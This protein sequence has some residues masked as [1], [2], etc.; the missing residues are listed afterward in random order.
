MDFTMLTLAAAILTILQNS[1]LDLTSGQTVATPIPIHNA[2]NPVLKE[3]ISADSQSLMVNG[4]RV[5]WAMGEFHYSRYPESEWRHELQKMK[6]GGINVISTYIIWIHHEES[7]DQWKWEGNKDLRKFLTLCKELGLKAFVRGGPWV[8]A[9]VRNGGFPDWMASGFK[10]RSDDPSYLAKV[11]E[12]YGQISKQMSGLA[13][14]DGGPIVGFQV[15]NEYYGP[16]E[17]LLNLKRMAQEVGINVPLYTRTGWP[18]LKTPVPPNEL[19]PMYGGYPIGFWDRGIEETAQKYGRNYTLRLDRNPDDILQGDAPK[20]KTLEVESQ[21]PYMCCEI[22]GG[23]HVSYHRR[24]VV[25]P[26]DIGSLAMAKVASGNNLQG[27][28]MYHGGTNPEGNTYLSESQAT[29]YWNDVPVK[30][31]DFQAP[32]GEFGQLRPHYHYLRRLHLFMKDFGHELA[33]M[34]AQIGS[35]DIANWSVRSNGESGFIFVNNYVRQI[36]QSVRKGVQFSL[37]CK[38]GPLTVP[39]KPIDIPENSYF[40]WPFHQD[41]S[42]VQLTYATAQPVCKLKDSYFFGQIKGVPAEFA[43]PVGDAKVLKTNAQSTISGGQVRLTKLKT[44]LE[45]AI[46]LQ[47]KDGKLVQI[48]LLAEAQSFHTWKGSFG[49]KEVVVVADDDVLFDRNQLQLTSRPST[50]KFVAIMPAFGPITIGGAAVSPS[51]VGEFSVYHYANPVPASIPITMNQTAVMTAP[52]EVVEGSQGVAEQPVDNDFD[53]ASKWDIILPKELPP[54]NWVLK[55]KYQGDV[56]RIY[57]N[58]NFV[59]DNF[60][61]GKPFE[62]GLNRGG[63]SLLRGSLSLSVLPWRKDALIYFTPGMKPDVEGKTGA[64]NVI[65][66]ELV[67]TVTVVAKAK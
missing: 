27:Y 16:G 18:M 43:F 41:L 54:G 52:R 20:P 60:Y 40:F 66:A 6:A 12:F 17:Y 9:E 3:T 65:S 61:N 25:E 22:G 59:N 36:P 45:P 11:K 33:G 28:Y 19:F 53:A 10:L 23:M 32:L 30:S 2:Y 48:Y 29:G 14:K 39:S 56:A 37:K 31:Y 50:S 44:G 26:N 8:H 55:I 21:Y 58:G 24:V 46:T 49:N 51:R 67:G 1:T 5:M 38:S 4:K 63:A 13:W 57:Q 34:R 15:E 47:K 42:G 64:C 35:P 7:Q 62:L